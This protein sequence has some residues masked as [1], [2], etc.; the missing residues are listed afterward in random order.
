MLL[1]FVLL[2][3]ATVKATLASNKVEEEMGKL[4]LRNL[5][6]Y[7]EKICEMGAYRLVPNL[8][9]AREIAYMCNK[10]EILLQSKYQN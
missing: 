8:V 5:N 2:L 10:T 3:T 4:T 6:D 9:C 7:F 1:I